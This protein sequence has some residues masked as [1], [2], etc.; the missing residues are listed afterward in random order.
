MGKI[1]LNQDSLR[2]ELTTDVDITGATLL[3]IRYKKPVSGDTGEWTAI[4]GD[5]G[6]GMIYYD[7][8]GTELDE[9]GTWTFWAYVTFSDNRSAPGEPV[10]VTVYTEGE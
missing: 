9:V 3:E 8:T 4:V 7:L 6:A 5:P 1:Y 2:I 10:K